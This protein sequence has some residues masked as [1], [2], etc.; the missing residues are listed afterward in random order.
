MLSPSAL[1]SR[2]A[3]ID[4]IRR[5]DTVAFC[6]VAILNLAALVIMA[7]TEVDLVAKAAFLLAWTFLNFFWLAL[8]RRPIAAAL[9]SIEI[10]VA[11]IL[12]SQFKHDKL[13]MTVDF[14]DLMIIDQDTSAFLLTAIPSLRVPM[15]LV[16]TAAAAL[17]GVAWRL[18]PFRIRVG[19]SVI[20]SSLCMGALVALSLL[21]PTDLYED[22]F[23][24]NYVSKFARTGVEAIRELIVH[25]YLES[26]VNVAERLK[27]P[28]ATCNPSRKLPHIILIHDESSFDITVAPG[29]HV[30][31]GYHHHFRSFDGKSRT[32][33]VEGRTKLVHRIQRAHRT[34]GPFLRGASLHP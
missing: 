6:L 7:A 4:A 1:P 11:L 28:A 17:L 25:G 12:L 31:S 15:A 23:S 34:L 22:F 21:F 14:V 27:P 5:R 3:P 13:W 32:L 29:M 19:T 8:F 30:P 10:V 16:V 18:D 24:Q 26:D 33:V 20:G 9:V 2:L